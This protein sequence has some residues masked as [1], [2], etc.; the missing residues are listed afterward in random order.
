MI[1][2]FASIPYRKTP[3]FKRAKAVAEAQKAALHHRAGELWPSESGQ[4]TSGA[5]RRPRFGYGA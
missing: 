2:D 4:S 5:L 3:A 1:R